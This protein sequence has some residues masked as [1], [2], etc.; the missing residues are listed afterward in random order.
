VASPPLVPRTTNVMVRPFHRP[1][2]A[3]FVP[4]GASSVTIAAMIKKLNHS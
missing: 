2:L 3:N 4:A 1:E